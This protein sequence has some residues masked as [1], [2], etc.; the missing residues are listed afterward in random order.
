MKNFA[1]YQP[2]LDFWQRRE[3]TTPV[4]QKLNQL[5]FGSNFQG[6]LRPIKDCDWREKS[7]P[8]LKPKLLV[9]Q[10]KGGHSKLGNNST[11]SDLGPTFRITS[12]Q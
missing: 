12:D 8:P 7:A 11:N 9:R 4:R 2:K 5:E 10:K 3:E 1:P 6:N